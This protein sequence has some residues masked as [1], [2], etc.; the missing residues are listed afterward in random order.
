MNSG[1]VFRKILFKS[2]FNRLQRSP[3]AGKRDGPDL[4]SSDWVRRFCFSSTFTWKIL[5]TFTRTFPTFSI[6]FTQYCCQMVKQHVFPM[7]VGFRAAAQVQFR[8]PPCESH[9]GAPI[10]AEAGVTLG[11]DPSGCDPRCSWRT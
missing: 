5:E 1:R 8:D 3:H 2:E 11:G 10:R 7:V 4:F 6:G 9:A